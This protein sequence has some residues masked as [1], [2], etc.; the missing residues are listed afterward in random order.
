VIGELVTEVVAR[1][2]RAVASNPACV[3]NEDETTVPTTG[4][5]HALNSVLFNLGMEMGIQFDPVVE[6]LGTRAETWL[7]MVESG[8]IAPVADVTGGGTPSY[9]VPE[10]ERG[11]L[12]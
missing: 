11:A 3:L 2:R 6:S 1:Y 5:R 8:S 12:G 4:F 7:R 10:A 9:W